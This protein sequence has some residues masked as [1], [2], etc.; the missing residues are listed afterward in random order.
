MR[1]RTQI[2]NMDHVD[3]TLA[4]HQSKGRLSSDVD[5]LA[6]LPGLTVDGVRTRRRRTR[7]ALNGG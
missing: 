1:R 5:Q 6:S 3:K 4:N 7:S 2:M